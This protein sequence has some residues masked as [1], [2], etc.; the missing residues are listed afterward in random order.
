MA[1]EWGTAT[2]LRIRRVNRTHFVYIRRRR[3][4]SR[5]VRCESA[6]V[7][8]STHLMLTHL[9]AASHYR[10]ASSQICF[11]HIDAALRVLSLGCNVD[12]MTGPAGMR[13]AR[14]YPFPHDVGCTKRGICYVLRKLKHAPRQLRSLASASYSQPYTR[15]CSRP[16]AR[17]CPN[18]LLL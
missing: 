4:P 9:S 3:Q 10:V 7:P 6:P 13:K 12:G 14:A 5:C 16:V 1:I 17:P 8:L 15:R 11:Y 18:N 2:L